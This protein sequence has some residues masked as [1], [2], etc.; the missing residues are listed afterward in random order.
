MNRRGRVWSVVSGLSMLAASTAVTSI[1]TA[2]PSLAAAAAVPITTAFNPVSPL[3]L[4][5]TRSGTGYGRPDASTIRVVIN[6]RDG[7]PRHAAAVAVTLTVVD[8]ST[9][10]YLTAYPNGSNRPDVSNLNF[11]RGST[12]ANT[13]VVQLG[14]N[15]AIN[16]FS[17]VAG[18]KIVVD[19]SGVFLP[20]AAP[21]A[22]GRYVAVPGVRA[23]DTRNEGAF[24]AGET[25]VVRFP[26][27]IVAPGA[28]AVVANFTYL[29]PTGPGYFTIWPGGPRPNASN[30]N[31]DAHDQTR[32]H[33]AII[34]VS[35][36]DAMASIS[37]FSSAGA[38][39]LVDVTGYFTG[40]DTPAD[41][42]GLFVPS[43]PWRAL[44][45]RVAGQPVS[46]EGSVRLFAGTG[47]AAWTNV[48][49]VDAAAPGFVTTRPAFSPLPN[50]SALNTSAAGKVI[51]NAA[52]INLSSEGAQL[53][54]SAGEH[55]IADVSG[56]FT[57][58]A[59]PTMCRVVFLAHGGGY[60]GGSSSDMITWAARLA[61]A[62]WQVVNADYRVS[63]QYS[64]KVW[65]S[66]YP[67]TSVYQPIPT[68]MK[69]AHDLA[70]ADLKPQVR[71]ALA[72]GCITHLLGYSSGGSAL[73]D[74]AQ[75]LNG[76]ATLQVVAGAILDLEDVGGPTMHVWHSQNDPIITDQ[77]ATES[78]PRWWAAD[79]LCTLH[80]LGQQPS[81]HLSVELVEATDWL[82]LNG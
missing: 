36:V 43:A 50:T 21:T 74:A 56:V 69:Q 26:A 68:E 41:D 2:Q 70:S 20:V 38:H 76:I 44:D 67:R 23:L 78:C 14:T 31:L 79:S 35:V 9:S 10:G 4:A 54:S 58:T 82:L 59:T 52:V 24:G 15:G 48:T 62:G 57:G 72:R 12:I 63:S 77:A 16:V 19:I 8:S 81:P 46:A 27:T 3:R 64:E 66:W 45:T 29:D 61:L 60:T 40:A 39:V 42:D 28:T 11:E 73:S 75:N 5:D 30:G 37:I 6:G 33:L 65:G 17:S 49:S 71:S 51:A 22:S 25:R 7:V 32:A 53:Y 80:D 55:L 18:A 13:A 34:P 47:I 1:V